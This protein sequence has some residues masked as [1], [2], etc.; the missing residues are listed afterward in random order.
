MQKENTPYD[1]ELFMQR[2][3]DLAENGLG[4]VAPNPMVGAVVVHEGHIIGEGYHHRFGGPHAEVL[5]I[6][7]VRNPSLLTESTLYVN[8]E[9]CAHQGKTPPCTNR[10]IRERIP[11]VVIGTVD[12]HSLVA[13]KGIQ[14]LRDAGVEVLV[15]VLTD[16]C[17]KLNRRYFTFHKKKRPYLIL[18]WAQTLD[19]F[20]DMER[21]PGTPIGINWITAEISRTLVHRWRSEEQGILV[22][23]KTVL[24]D[25]PKLN[26]RNWE[27]HDPVRIVLDRH[28][29]LPSDRQVFDGTLPTL[30]Y[31]S[32]I[33]KEEGLTEWVKA[34]FSLTDLFPVLT[35]LYQR[36]ILSV[37]VEGGRA[38]LDFFLLNDL[39]DEARV[40][41]GQKYF[42]DRKSVV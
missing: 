23:T 16:S 38:L 42:E 28:L 10:I 2:C 6:E 30:I 1:H 25:D 4:R 12:P 33:T 13:G 17:L 27:G 41:T 14:K 15:E 39:W 29:T 35:D 21:E 26:I 36:N 9:P 37:M 3:L 19:G 24:Y 22:G 32:R 11:R 31:N 5:A 7:A 40:F 34:E 8:L 20:I 18:K